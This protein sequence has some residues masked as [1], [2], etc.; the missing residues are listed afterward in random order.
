MDS[1]DSGLLYV[2][3]FAAQHGSLNLTD[4]PG[5]TRTLGVGDNF[6]QADIDNGRLSYTHTGKCFIR[7]EAGVRF[8]GTKACHELVKLC[9]AL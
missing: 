6:T 3:T 8:L 1:D 9:T 2:I 4:H 5:R 7:R